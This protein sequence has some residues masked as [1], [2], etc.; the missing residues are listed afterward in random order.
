MS[1]ITIAPVAN[2]IGRAGRPLS[3]AQRLSRLRMHYI[4]QIGLDNITPPISEAILA[5]VE[6]T[7]MAS[8]L[9]RKIT[10]SGAAS[11][12]DLMALVRLENSAA[13]AVARLDLPAKPG[14]AV[15]VD[16]INTHVSGA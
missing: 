4:R 16:A 13:R 3:S 5:A 9:R 15:E 2:E 12:E 6:L 11:A 14:S 7:V 10:K 1:D 8:E